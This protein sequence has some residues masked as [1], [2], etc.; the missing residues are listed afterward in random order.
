MLS[1][2]ISYAYLVKF[3][4]FANTSHSRGMKHQIKGA[5]QA[6]EGMTL[7]ILHIF[8]CKDATQG[9][10]LDNIYLVI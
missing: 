1:L 3:H 8:F 9:K 7:P 10:G 4:Y 6:Q 2:R 5:T